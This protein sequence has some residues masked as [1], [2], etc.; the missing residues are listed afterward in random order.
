VDGLNQYTCECLPV[1]SGR[2]CGTTNR[3]PTVTNA[4]GFRCGFTDARLFPQVVQGVVSQTLCAWIPANIS[5]CGYPVIDFGRVLDA[6]TVTPVYVQW[7]NV[8]WTPELVLSNAYVYACAE[9]TRTGVYYVI[10]RAIESNCS[11]VR[12]CAVLS[13]LPALVCSVAT[14]ENALAWFKD[15]LFIGLVVVVGVLV[16]ISL[17]VVLVLHYSVTQPITLP[18]TTATPGV[19]SDSTENA[20]QENSPDSLPLSSI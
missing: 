5:S 3:N 20:P 6:T 10:T 17:T 8:V 19:P 13:T 2:Q 4:L 15:N 11:T 9:V 1:F 7:S 16:V 12:E 18:P 14:P